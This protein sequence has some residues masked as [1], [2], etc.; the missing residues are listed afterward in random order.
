[1]SVD[2]SLNKRGKHTPQAACFL[3]LARFMLCFSYTYVN[4]YVA[5]DP[6]LTN[7]PCGFYLRC[8]SL[9]DALPLRPEGT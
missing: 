7:Q 1:M 5:C 8:T 4:S 6:S 2:K 9:V 3:L